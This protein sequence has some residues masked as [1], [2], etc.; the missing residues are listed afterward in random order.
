M[1]GAAAQTA[2]QYPL[3]AGPNPPH[4]S[5]EVN[6]TQCRETAVLLQENYASAQLRTGFSI[7]YLERMQEDGIAK[8]IVSFLPSSDLPSTATSVN[9]PD[10]LPGRKYIVN[11]Y[12]ISEEGEQNLILSTSQTTGMCGWLLLHFESC[13][14]CLLKNFLLPLISHLLCSCVYCLKQLLMHHLTTQWR[15]W[16]THP[17]SSAGADHRLQ[18]QVCPVGVHLFCIIGRI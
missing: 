8:I 3:A 11:V 5:S 18:S 13:C 2:L 4:N 10:L 14:F 1:Q 12:Q 16:M 15:V 6:Q 9:I 7:I 17:L